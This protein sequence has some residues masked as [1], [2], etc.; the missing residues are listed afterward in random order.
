MTENDTVKA[1]ADGAVAR[2]L[3]ADGIAYAAAFALAVLPFLWIEDLLAAAAAFTATATAVLF[4]VSVILADVSVYDPYWSVAPPVM[5]LAV[6]IKYDLWNVNALVLLAAVG[7]WSLR[8]TAN[9]LVT[10][11]G[12]GHEDWRYRAYREKYPPFVFQCVSFCGLHFVPTIVVYA[13]LVSGLLAVQRERFAPLSVIGL[14]V[15][16][17]AVLLEHVSDRAIHRFLREHAGERRTCDISVWKYSRHP[18]YLGEMSFWCG[19]YV[20]FAARC[21]EIWYKGLGFLCVIAL[22]LF[23]S[24]PMMEKHNAA[25][26]PDYA[27]YRARTPMLLPLPPRGREEEEDANKILR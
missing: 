15:M 14:L 21:P 27:A 11:R 25:R 10:Y 9:W 2:G 7:V 8:L 17:G 13:A 4:A 26:R 20:Y 12:L 24:I 18:N 22:F 6:M 3:L 5:L 23:V 16:L 1:R 19:L